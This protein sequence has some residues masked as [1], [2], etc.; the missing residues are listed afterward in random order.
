MSML[1]KPIFEGKFEKFDVQDEI[2]A[3]CLVKNI[4]LESVVLPRNDVTVIETR[5]QKIENDDSDMDDV[6]P[7]PKTPALSKSIFDEYCTFLSQK[8]DKVF[9]NPLEFWSSEE[10]GLLKTLAISI[11]CTQASS[12]EPERHNSAAGLMMSPLRNQ[13]LGETL[14]KQVIYNEYLKNK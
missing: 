10:D 4:P 2:E 9:E 1:K 5:T 6:E 8:P 12:A 11:F 7:D 13:L 14:E 3:C